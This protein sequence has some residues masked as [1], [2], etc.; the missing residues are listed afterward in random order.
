[1][2]NLRPQEPAY[3]VGERGWYRVGEPKLS[4]IQICEVPHVYS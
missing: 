2:E 3:K 1:V 4:L